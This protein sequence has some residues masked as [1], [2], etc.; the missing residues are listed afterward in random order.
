MAIPKDL[1]VIG[2]VRDARAWALS[3]HSKPWHTPRAMQRLPL[4]TFLRAPWETII[5]RP[6]YF[7]DIDPGAIGTPLQADRQADGAPY[8]NL[9]ALRR[10]KLAG[11][12]SYMARG[13]SFA[14]VRMEE[15]QA[16]PHAFCARLSSRLGLPENTAEFRPVVKRLGSKFKASVP[17]RPETPEALSESQMEFLRT[18][19]DVSAERQ[20]GYDYT[21]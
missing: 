5:D 4:D 10:G 20:L 11:L 6:R 9:F 12:M 2:V 14:L 15:A 3:M 13:C 18:E 21:A 16:D 17:D 7:G 1:I 19:L 8:P